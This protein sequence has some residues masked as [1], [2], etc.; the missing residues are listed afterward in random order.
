MTTIQR[1]QQLFKENACWG[2]HK[3]DGI[4]KGN[5]G[6]ELTLEGR[7]A[8]YSTIEHQLWDPRYKVANCVM[9]YFFSVKVD[10][11]GRSGERF[12]VDVHGR[13]HS[14]SKLDVA[15]SSQIAPATLETLA[16]HRQTGGGSYYYFVPLKKH[17]ADVD[18][19]TTYILAQTGQNYTQSVSGRLSRLD[20]YNGADPPTVPVTVDAGKL[21]FEQSGCYACHYLGD[22]NNDKIGIG[23]IAA[24]NLSWEGSRHS[25]QWV[26]AH[27]VNP[28]AFVP[29]S[30]M[31]VFPLSD[32]QRAALSLYD[33]SFIPKGGRP[34][35]PNE[36]MPS[37]AYT[38]N[39]IVVP[40]VRYMTR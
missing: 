20:A 10:V 26:D 40:E 18:A 1:G 2:C 24:P 14:V 8:V 39:K 17:Q 21:V 15:D 16:E 34:V 33:T 23:G 3:V 25:R 4:S 28:Q 32:S 31:P 12:W 6:P 29:K 37:T 38:A 35:S 36:D 9:P 27:Y 5:V 13:K 7:I 30:I 11:D 19:L 22:P